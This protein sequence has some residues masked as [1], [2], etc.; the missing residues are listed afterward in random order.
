MTVE[1]DDERWMRHAIELARHCPPSPDAFSVGAVVVV[2]NEVVAQGY[3]RQDNPHDHAEEVALRA[4][5][6]APGRE[7]TTQDDHIGGGDL[8]DA[9]IYSTMEPCGERA[10]RPIP[11]AQLI[12]QSGLTRVVYAVG[13]PT[14]FVAAPRGAQ[15]LREAGLTVVY[16]PELAKAARE[17]SRPIMLV[18][19]ICL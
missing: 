15:L 14:T 7:M 5:R 6:L 18:C 11:C 16:L 2:E 9:T 10:S 13:E 4:L 19:R 1:S 3:S 17:V 8:T 12:I